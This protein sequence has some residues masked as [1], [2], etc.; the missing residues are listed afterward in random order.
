ML[1]EEIKQLKETT[2][3][4]IDETSDLKTGFNYTVVDTQK[5][6][7]GLGAAASKVYYS[8]SPLSIGGYGEMYFANK[9]SDGVNG[10]TS[11]VDLYRFIPYIGYKFSDNIILNTELEFEHGGIANNDGTAEGGAVVIEFYYLD[12]LF[13][14][15]F[16]VRAGNLLVPMGYVNQKHE[17][18]LFTTVQRPNTSKYLIPSTWS[19]SGAMVY[20]TI[21]ENIDYKAGLVTGLDD[22]T[23]GYKWIRN[24]RGGSFTNEDPSLGGFV[25][26]DYTG[27]KGL[28]VGAAVYADNRIKMF[29]IHADYKIGAFEAYGVYTQTTRSNTGQL[30][31]GESTKAKGGYLNLSYDILS[32]TSS[33]YRAPIFIQYDSVDTQAS[34]VAPATAQYDPV[35]TTT[36]G[37]N[38]YPHEQ[39]VFKVDYAMSDNTFGNDLSTYAKNGEDV[40]S[41]SLGFIF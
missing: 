10:S 26:V 1:K 12:F 14:E 39:V 32:L 25:R 8:K 22:N 38:F 9:K 11:K 35:N 19:E 20:G 13:N 6:H 7:S 28:L 5:S 4:L 33:K 37:I 40:F 17:P 41:F 29:D 2:Q 3:A 34:L 15:N 30:A 31:A 21:N 24:A 36:V 18:T 16:N 23:T 27:I